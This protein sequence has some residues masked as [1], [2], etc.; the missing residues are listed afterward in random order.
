MDKLKVGQTRFTKKGGEITILYV[1]DNMT[2][3]S[4]AGGVEWANENNHLLL[5]TSITRSTPRI[6]DVVWFV[7]SHGT[8]WSMIK[9]S[10]NYKYHKGRE[11]YKRV[12]F[13]KESGEFTELN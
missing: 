9:D 10:E 5:E 12:Y 1:G 13:N 7:N 3:F 2:M 6:I 8:L 4:D 11:N